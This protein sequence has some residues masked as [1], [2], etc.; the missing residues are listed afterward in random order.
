MEVTISVTE[1]VSK[2]ASGRQVPS[3]DPG[4]IGVHAE[5]MGSQ[6]NIEEMAKASDQRALITMN[7]HDTELKTRLETE[8]KKIRLARK[9]RVIFVM[10]FVRG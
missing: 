4:F 6:R 9:I 2:N 10:P 7:V 8:G 5:A 3:G 1:R